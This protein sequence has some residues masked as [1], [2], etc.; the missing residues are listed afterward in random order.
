MQLVVLDRLVGDRTSEQRHKRRSVIEGSGERRSTAEC[1]R[2]ETPMA[3]TC[4]S[5]IVPAE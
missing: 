1:T 3:G 2:S 5:V 4:C